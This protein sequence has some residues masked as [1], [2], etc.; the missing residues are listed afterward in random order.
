METPAADEIGPPGK[1]HWDLLACLWADCE[2]LGLNPTHLQPMAGKLRPPALVVGAGQGLLVGALHDAGLH[3]A[4]GLDNSQAMLRAATE[5]RGQIPLLRAEASNL[6]FPARTWSTLIYAT[7]VLNPHDAGQLAACRDE[8]RRVT[9]SGASVIVG[10]FQPSAA[11]S[12]MGRDL[13]LLVDGNLCYPRLLELWRRR[14]D[15]EWLEWAVCHWT[16]C[17]TNESATRLRHWCKALESWYALLDRLAARLRDQGIAS[18]Q[19]YLP[20]AFGWRLPG[21]CDGNLPSAFRHA[22]LRPLDT[23]YDESTC[24]RVFAL[25]RCE[26]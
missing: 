4:V 26:W 7:G 9:A 8:M 23:W 3:P 17:K 21:L 6:P 10:F 16:G 1:D 13:G 12:A 20:R 5:R 19:A 15:L 14:F 25:R 2:Q 18:P 22:D 24:T 11:L